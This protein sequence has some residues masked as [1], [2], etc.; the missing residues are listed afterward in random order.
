MPPSAA[1]KTMCAARPSCRAARRLRHRAGSRSATARR[2]K[3]AVEWR[4]QVPGGHLAAGDDGFSPRP[5]PRMHDARLTP[6]WPFGKSPRSTRRPFGTSAAG[7]SDTASGN[8]RPHNRPARGTAPPAGT[9]RRNRDNSNTIAAAAHTAA[10]WDSSRRTGNARACNSHRT[11]CPR[12]KR[13]CASA[14]LREARAA[15]R[16]RLAKRGA[17]GRSPPA[18][19]PAATLG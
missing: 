14:A 17:P 8:N 2:R 19:T 10:A 3:P 9:S 15:F 6:P 5:F 13:T 18:T 4:N 11:T 7:T 1:S 16:P 12:N